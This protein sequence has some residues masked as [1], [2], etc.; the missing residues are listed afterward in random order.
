LGQILAL[1]GDSLRYD[2]AAMP[3]MVFTDPQVASVGLTEDSAGAAGYD[4]RVSVLALDHCP[5]RWPPG[6]SGV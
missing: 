3:A 6:T 2:S 4:G 5:A 1:N